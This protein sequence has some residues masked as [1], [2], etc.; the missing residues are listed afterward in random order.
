MLFVDIVKAF[1]TINHESLMQVI[2]KYMIPKTLIDVITH[3]YSGF[4]LQCSIDSIEKRIPY[5]I[6]VHQG[7]NLAPILFNLFF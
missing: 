3:I 2:T 1:D 6:R 4:E 5:T 7:N